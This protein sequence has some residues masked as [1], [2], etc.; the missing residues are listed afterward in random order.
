MAAHGQG[1]K[2]H[3]RLFLE[4]I[5][6][7]VVGAS[8]NASI[9]SGA[10]ANVQVVPTDRALELKP[11]TL[12]HLFY[13]DEGAGPARWTI[14]EDEWGEAK[15][16]G[17]YR[18]MFCGEIVS[19]SMSKSPGSRS[20][21]FQCLDTSSYWDTTFQYM[22]SVSSDKLAE[23]PA[24]YL[25]ASD[26]LFDD[27]VNN[28]ST[29]LAGMLTKTPL[30]P[31]LQN[32]TGLLGGV[33]HTLEAVGGVPGIRAGANLYN[34]IAELRVK[35]THQ[36]GA[37]EDD[38]TAGELFKARAFTQW[39]ENSLGGMGDLVSFRDVVGLFNSHTYHDVCPNPTPRY[40]LGE[41]VSG[42]SDEIVATSAVSDELAAQEI[43]EYHSLIGG[44][45]LDLAQRCV[46]LAHKIGADPYDLAAIIQKESEWN[47][48]SQNVEN[49]ED[50]TKPPPGTFA[51]GLIQFTP[52]N[53]YDLPPLA[54]RLTDFERKNVVWQKKWGEGIDD[55][56]LN[57][58]ELAD[59]LD[60]TQWA[61][62]S[63]GVRILMLDVD[64]HFELMHQYFM[65][66]ERP[67]AEGW[68]L[69]SLL[70]KVFYPDY[71]NKP[72][73]TRFPDDVIAQQQGKSALPPFTTP[74]EYTALVVPKLVPGRG[75]GLADIPTREASNFA[76]KR[77][78]ARLLT[79]IIRPDVWFVAP[80]R[81]NVIFPEQQL[82]VNYARGYMREVSRIQLRTNLEILGSEENA[83]LASFNYSPRVEEF[84]KEFEAGGHL[85]KNFTMQHERFTG[86]V[87]RFERMG[88]VNF[89]ANKTLTEAR[90]AQGLSSDADALRKH[91]ADF[92]FFRHRFSSRSMEV[93]CYFNPYLALGFPG[94]VI[95]R[96]FTPPG[97]MTVQQ[98]FSKIKE[99]VTG[100]E[101]EGG[102]TYL[103]TAMLGLISSLSHSISQSGG[104]SS[105][106]FTQA[107]SHRTADGSDDEFLNL[108]IGARE[109]ALDGVTMVT[110]FDHITSD[111]ADSPEAAKFLYG[112]SVDPAP[113]SS[114]AAP[115]LEDLQQDAEARLLD[116]VGINGGKITS[117][118]VGG[119]GP[120][121]RLSEG[122]FSVPA[123]VPDE[124]PADHDAVFFSDI[125]IEER[126]TFSDEDKET[127]ATTKIQTPVEMALFPPWFSD[128]YYND[129]I[130]KKV[131]EPLFGTGSVVDDQVFQLSN[132][133]RLGSLRS[134]HVYVDVA[135]TVPSTDGTA[136]AEKSEVRKIKVEQ[137]VS[138]AQAVDALATVYGHL[139]S[140]QGDHLDL[141][142]FIQN[143]TFRPVARMDEVL[144]R[145][146]EF[147]KDGALTKGEEGFH[148]RAVAELTG[149]KGL[150][151]DPNK[152]MPKVS[153]GTPIQLNPDMDPRQARRAKV[154]AYRRE[155]LGRGGDLGRGLEG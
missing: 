75:S 109:R 144:G 155:L 117:V 11:R 31:D 49:W 119:V 65:R 98:V 136:A 142:K 37:V 83:L 78:A 129:K 7:P 57:E 137:S 44:C 140:S 35:N 23:R 126:V 152:R 51:T 50:A 121:I 84:R 116:T 88:Q 15:D 128:V 120:L 73:N 112:R 34:T 42:L 110:H 58:T 41:R 95:Q 59:Q 60:N 39:L 18:L 104:T 16:R 45:N 92:N 102:I 70:M 130:G 56:G 154:L 55:G 132:A 9:G 96:G 77:R 86:I 97:D 91:V 114:T 62:R 124:H 79:Q 69:R 145:H 63:V 6:V 5:E 93:S 29:V 38:V 17:Q 100:F 148:S 131:Y 133:D 66:G 125:I 115:S 143:Y 61:R 94:V 76:E 113:A 26:N 118:M 149:L 82:S 48:A 32:A 105:A 22:M 135:V 47:I 134:D 99:S 90:A 21:T 89:F 147:G 40:I 12:V 71:I 122:A 151:N 28:P 74:D 13:L 81:C 80:P 101:L 146:V 3:L 25:G 20:V 19:V 52:A 138:I 68:S 87:P 141:T 33:I 103:P 36:V 127:F 153:M 107:R 10:S 8:V 111:I 72:G 54:A 43:F 14:P 30:T 53:V 85:T 67:P 1:R 123:G 64:E 139:K 4:G 108:F 106:S 24:A 150:I 2:I 27:V 46:A